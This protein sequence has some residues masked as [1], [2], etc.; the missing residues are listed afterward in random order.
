MN[1]VQSSGSGGYVLS[2]VDRFVVNTT[3]S[4][5]SRKA[6]VI[7]A[8]SA[9]VALA[10]AAVLYRR[11]CNHISQTT[12]NTPP[13]SSRIDPTILDRQ[14]EVLNLQQ[15][16]RDLENAQEIAKASPSSSI[17]H[18]D[19]VFLIQQQEVL[20]LQ[21]E[22]FRLR[23]A[24]EGKVSKDLASQVDLIRLKLADLN[25]KVEGLEKQKIELEKTIN[26]ARSKNDDI[27]L[28]NYLAH[29]IQSK[30]SYVNQ[31]VANEQLLLTGI[32]PPP[33]N[34]KWGNRARGAPVTPQERT[35]IQ[36]G[37]RTLDSSIVSVE[38]KIK[39]CEQGDYS[40]CL[41]F[42]QS[43]PAIRGSLSVYCIALANIKT[44]EQNITAV[45]I[46]RN[47]LD[48]Q[49]NVLLAH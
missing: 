48:G 22:V 41:E 24:S 40:G 15:R 23:N 9:L 20:R 43:S 32:H 28:R 1:Q 5:Q 2:S 38:G 14:Q 33:V 25:R 36:E 16:I 47:K 37:I 19:S 12:N 3:N 10:A 13:S 17:P 34:S 42:Y 46:E 30:N 45:Q 8:V 29:L 31:K 4:L 35:V 39:A 7:V 6:T 11:A 26:Y 44:V 18:T 49:M 21:A 27:Y